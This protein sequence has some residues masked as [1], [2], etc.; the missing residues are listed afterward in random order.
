MKYTEHATF[1]RMSMQCTE[2]T[3]SHGIADCTRKDMTENA[4]SSRNQNASNVFLLFFSGRYD[5]RPLQGIILKQTLPAA[6]TAAHESKRQ[7][8]PATSCNQIAR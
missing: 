2:S 1:Q 3:C 6:R 7:L 4:Y 5:I 8:N